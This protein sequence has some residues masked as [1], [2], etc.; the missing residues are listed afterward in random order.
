[1]DCICILKGSLRSR[2][3]RWRKKGVRRVSGGMA[4]A[5]AVTMGTGM[6]MVMGT[7]ILEREVKWIMGM[8]LL[9]GVLGWV[10]NLFMGVG[11][12]SVPRRM[13]KVYQPLSIRILFLE[14]LVS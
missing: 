1:M 3:G 4:M 5:V 7:G 9:R 12:I 13:N 10:I 14:G 2:E 6:A 11:L 8:I